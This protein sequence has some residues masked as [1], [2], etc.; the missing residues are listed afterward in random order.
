MFQNSDLNSDLKFGKPEIDRKMPD[1]NF[2]FLKA[3]VKRSFTC[4]LKMTPS[5]V[6]IGN[7][8]ILYTEYFF[9]QE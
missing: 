2:H 9:E 4:A 1:R 5:L 6:R 3:L 7:N 8:D